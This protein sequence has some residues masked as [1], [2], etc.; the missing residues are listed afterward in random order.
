LPATRADHARILVCSQPTWVHPFPPSETAGPAWYGWVDRIV[1]SAPPGSVRVRL[2]P[3]ERDIRDRLAL[4]DAVIAAATHRTSLA[5][6][7]AETDSVVAPF[8]TVLIEAAAAGRRVLSVIPEAGCA[9]VRDR[10]PALVDREL[11][12]CR[13]DD[14]PDHRALVAALAVH[15]DVTEWGARYARVAPD[16]ASRCATALTDLVAA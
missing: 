16:T 15:G 13:V 9:S 8:S 7:L 4:G 2:H 14:V 10:S 1:R 5:E 12:V 11:A 3:R 6:D